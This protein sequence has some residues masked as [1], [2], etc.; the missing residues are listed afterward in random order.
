MRLLLLAVLTLLLAAPAA[1]QEHGFLPDTSLYCPVTLAYAEEGDRPGGGD[2]PTH[3]AP[4]AA[5][6]YA[7]DLARRIDPFPVAGLDGEALPF[8]FFGGFNTPR[9]QLA[10]LTGDGAPD[11]VVLEAPGHVILY[12]NVGPGPDGGPAAFEWVTDDWQGLDVGS[13]VR[14]GDLDGDGD[15]DAL[16]QEFSGQ[17]RYYRND[18]T[19]TAPD[20]VL[21]AAPL[22]DTDGDPVFAE[23]P[24]VPAL[25]DVDADGRPDLFMGQADLGFIRH[26]RH[27]GVEDGVPQYE[28]VTNAFEGIQVFESNP[29]C[30]PGGPGAPQ[31]VPGSRLQSPASPPQKNG[32][33]GRPSLHGQNAVALADVTGDGA[34]ELFWGDFF[35][36]SLYYFVNVGTPSD[37]AFDPV[38]TSQ[39]YPLDDPLTSA[40]YN[41]P[42][43]GDLDGDAD[44]DLVVGI[45]GGFCSS[46]ASLVENLYLLEN[47]GTPSDADFE[48]R[49]D[50]LIEGVDVGRVSIP[51]LHD[52]DG[53]GD[54]DALV[55]SAYNPRPDPA[56]PGEAIG[57]SLAFFENTGSDADPAFRL[58]DYDY[59][60]LDLDFANHYAPAFGDLDNDGDADL[61]IGTF[62][63][64]VFLLRNDGFGGVADFAAPDTLFDASD[65][66]P[67]DIGQIAYP[68]LADLDAD[69]DLDLVVGEFGGNLNLYRNTGSAQDPEFTLE[70]DR[71]L[72]LDVGA[73]SAPA[74]ADL[75]SDGDPDLLV[76]SKDQGVL[77][78]RNIGTAQTPDFQPEATIETARVLSA[79]APADLDADGDVD[80]LVGDNAGGLLYFEADAGTTSGEATPVQPRGPRIEAF[81]N[82]H[83]GGVTLR[84]VGAPRGRATLTVLDAAG[85]EVRRWPL[86][87][88]RAEQAVRWDGL[89]TSG[90]EAASGVYVAR[91]T[92]DGSVLASAKLTRVR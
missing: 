23:D 54:L 86:P 73:S 68:A 61:L 5:Q 90:A 57:G 51:A 35:T 56:Q 30:R 69:G 11:L 79:P 81:P 44:L 18:G 41:V 34:P 6:D 77:V 70:D 37:P 4:A 49:T 65:D 38:E 45:V 82:P 10:D 19:M 66:D 76:G 74:F 91:L 17:V 87:A 78:F 55:G 71:Y 75:D 3:P 22:L 88:S 33:D 24:N 92:S 2:A 52:L 9:P 16:G 47:E 12:E 36:P 72:G 50:R 60:R 42:T 15:L 25:G 14:F 20:Y 67:L 31:M 62:G 83:G 58:A 48:E 59:L 64:K 84:V 32:G 43:F 7:D 27:T 80:L 89:T 53:D 39:Q 29:T 85:R 13:W 28:F 8:P 46:T 26:Y 40:G 1:A 63:G 21:A